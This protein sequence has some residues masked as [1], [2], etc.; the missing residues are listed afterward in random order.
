M[1][2]SPSTKFNFPKKQL[3]PAEIRSLVSEAVPGS[4][5]GKSITS[6]E[7]KAPAIIYPEP[8]TQPCR[9][10]MGRPPVNDPDGR[11]I[12]IK[13]NPS[14]LRA[15]RLQAADAEIT[16]SLAIEKIIRAHLKL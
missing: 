14:V 16:L 9:K 7:A 13:L 8:V 15:V 12:Q 6:E 1:T 11:R 10:K 5:G 4:N 3:D 2:D